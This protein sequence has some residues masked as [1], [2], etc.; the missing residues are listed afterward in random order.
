MHSG[1][2]QPYDWDLPISLLP[3][4]RTSPNCTTVVS[5]PHHNGSFP[6][7]SRKT[8]AN[9]RARKVFWI[10]PCMSPTAFR[11]GLS[12]AS[13]R[14]SPDF[15]VD[16]TKQNVPHAVYGREQIRCI[17]TRYCIL[18]PYWTMT[19]SIMLL[20]KWPC[21]KPANSSL[22]IRPAASQQT[23]KVGK[24]SKYNRSIRNSA[25]AT[26]YPA[27]ANIHCKKALALP[28]SIDFPDYWKELPKPFGCLSLWNL[29]SKSLSQDKTR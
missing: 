11:H 13:K 21:S 22:M 5:P 8:P 7:P 20:L 17:T 16:G 6:T 12:L 15:A 9:A 24:K 23:S 19:V 10:S 2:R 25:L 1:Q 14:S 26:S 18:R 3:R 4:S 29:C 27:T 28:S